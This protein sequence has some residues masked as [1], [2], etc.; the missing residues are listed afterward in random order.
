MCSVV[1]GEA[2]VSEDAVMV[3]RLRK[4]FAYEHCY[5][6]KQGIECRPKGQAE[7]LEDLLFIR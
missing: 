7:T 6:A 5:Y 2:R 1:G 4:V 3:M